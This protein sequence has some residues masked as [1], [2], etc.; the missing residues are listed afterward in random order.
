MRNSGGEWDPAIVFEQALGVSVK[1]VK[2]SLW[3]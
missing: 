1:D 3:H 2:V